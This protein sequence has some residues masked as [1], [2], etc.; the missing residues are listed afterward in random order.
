MVHWVWR[1]ISFRLPAEWEMLQFSSEYPLGR[2]AFADRRQ[3]RFEINWKIVKGEPDYDRMISDYISKLERENKLTEPGRVKKSGWFGF[4]GVIDGDRTSRFGRYFEPIE[5]LLECVFIW[6]DE[7][8]P[9]LEAEVLAS[10][11]AMPGDTDGF[12]RWR[13]FGLDMA[14]PTIA[15]L[16]G[17][18]AQPARAQFTFSNPKTGS[19]WSFERLG[20]TAVWLKCDVET[21]LRGHIDKSTKALRITHS[22]R[23]GSD[24]VRAEGTYK[25]AGLHLRR[26]R[27][28]A[29][30]WLCPEDRRLYYACSR[31]RGNDPD[32]TRPIEQL[33]TAAP[34][35]TPRHVS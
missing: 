20:M 29:E 4:H 23:H 28:T 6:P 21:W 17:C 31:I 11:K 33:L 7:R 13:A 22:S 19:E 14:I 10:F 3:F 5:C 15:A 24:V 34:D 16:E 12:Q 18:T 1:H 35:F 2:C 9:D 30:A 32:D 27:L 25:P 26:G 8:D